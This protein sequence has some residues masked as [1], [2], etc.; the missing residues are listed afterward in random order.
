[1]GAMIKTLV[2]DFQGLSL[3]DQEYVAEV[4]QKQLIESRR[5]YLAKRVSEAKANYR[6]GQCKSGSFKELMEDIESD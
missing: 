4:I 1:M 2:D 3:E 5:E 6:A